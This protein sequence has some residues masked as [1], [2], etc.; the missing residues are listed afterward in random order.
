MTAFI[1]CFAVISAI[2]AIYL[3]LIA[4]SYDSREGFPKSLMTP[5]A[6]RGLHDEEFPENSLPAFE[7]AVRS[8]YGIE[9]DL[10]LSSDGEVMVFH[11]ATLKRMCGI[12]GKLSD[13]PADELTRMNLGDSEYTIPLF[14]EVLETVDG[15]VPLLIELKGENGNT[16]LCD[17]LFELLDTYNGAFAIESFNPILLSC[18]R[19]KRPSYTRGQL[20]DLLT[21]ESYKGPGIVRFALSH[22]LLNVISRPHFIAY[23][24]KSNPAFAIKLASDLFGVKKFAWTVRT[25][26]EYASLQSK[27]IVSI[28][29]NFKP[30]EL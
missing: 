9:L 11:D 18:V 26:N 7:K 15:S 3:F 21:K 24:P 10:Q 30:H 8:G 5:Y 16:T 23:N 20:V 29:E 17:K 27:G 2:I 13:L 22:L 25:H 19:K 28:F 12:N 14:R 6:H 1:I 4:P